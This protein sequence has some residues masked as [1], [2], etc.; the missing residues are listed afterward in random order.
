MNE[1]RFDGPDI[2]KAIC[3]FLIVCIHAPFPGIIGTCVTAIARVGVPVFFMITGYFYDT[4][5]E[6]G[7]ELY[8]IKKIFLLMIFSNILYFVFDII[9]SLRD[10]A[11]SEFLHSTFTL[12]SLIKFLLFNESVLHGHL[13]YLG[14]I[15]YVLVIF[16]LLRK[17]VP[18]W[19]TAVYA[20]TPFL[21][22]EDLVL[23]KY[24]ILLF[25]KEPFPAFALRNFL[26][27]G[28]PYFTIGY[29]LKEN[30][31]KIDSFRKHKA[32]CGLLAL[33]FAGT[34]L[35]ELFI[36]KYLDANATRDHY[37]STTFLAIIL[38][39]IFTDDCWNGNKFKL[40][41]KIGKDYSALIYIVHPIFINIFNEIASMASAQRA[42]SFV[43]PIIVFAV[44]ALF[45]FLYYKI[46][47]GKDKSYEIK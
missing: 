3:A 16:K 47:N 12:K 7:K 27:V 30:R 31:R 20:I 41:K 42:Y 26:F 1:K 9:V 15:L 25:G 19:K 8:Q 10:C 36:L 18:K 37:I 44:T 45:A 32:L 35:F 33:L 39:I 5:I 13:W 28:I 6:K 14:A 11:V 40:T 21:L 2:L 17:F 46:K 43:K 22:I 29:F 38:F 4:V 24:S 34:T 23:G